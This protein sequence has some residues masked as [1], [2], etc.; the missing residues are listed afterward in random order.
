MPRTATNAS[1][2]RTTL[3]EP[4]LLLFFFKMPPQRTTRRN[5]NRRSSPRRPSTTARLADYIVSSPCSHSLMASPKS[6]M[7][8]RSSSPA[9]PSR[10]V[11]GGTMNP[12]VPAFEPTSRLP[13]A[14]R[15][16]LASAPASVSL[17]LRDG[18][19]S[20]AP[21]VRPQAQARRFPNPAIMAVG[22]GGGG[23]VTRV[24]IFRNSFIRLQIHPPCL[25]CQKIRRSDQDKP[26]KFRLTS[27]SDTQLQRRPSL[28]I[29]T[30]TRTSI[31]LSRQPHP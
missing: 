15:A 28:T 4:Q 14:P 1:A 19:R 2:S 25:L 11:S 13:S 10:S 9:P 20:R 12:N 23:G 26:G 6:E 21:S 16:M 7:D 5:R 29:P 27:R 18:S 8:D 31:Q 17:T 3:I 22:G 30:L 24:R